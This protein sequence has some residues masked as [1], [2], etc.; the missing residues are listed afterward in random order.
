MKAL[1][2]SRS[3][4][5]ADFERSEGRISAMASKEGDGRCPNAIVSYDGIHPIISRSEIE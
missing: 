3:V 4:E 2:V 5:A 1:A